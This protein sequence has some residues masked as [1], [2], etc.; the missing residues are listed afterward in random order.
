MLPK[1]RKQHGGIMPLPR[2]FSFSR[3]MQPSIR[4]AALMEQGVVFVFRHDSIAIREDG[5]THQPIE[6]L[7]SLR[8]IR[9]LIVIRARAAHGCSFQMCGTSPTPPGQ[10]RS[11]EKL[12]ER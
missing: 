2:R 4:L 11:S 8:A 7:A 1:K 6:Q 3:T 10:G 12:T 5:P 9:H